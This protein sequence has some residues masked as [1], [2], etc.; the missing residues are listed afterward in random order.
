MLL[1]DAGGDR[2]QTVA[3]LPAIIA[4]LRARGYRFVPVSEL[5]GLS[6]TA[7][8]PPISASDR[9][10]AR[11]DLILFTTLGDLTIALRWLFLIA[12]TLGI[13]RALV[14]SGLALR[15]ARRRHRSG[16]PLMPGYHRGPWRHHPVYER[17][18]TRHHLL[19]RT[20]S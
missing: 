1:H 15:Q 3:A 7:T 6:R 17:T 11:W 20:A 19:H 9:A 2:S 14:L 13:A 10:A 4:Q 8:M 16:T 18:G 12:V 5:A